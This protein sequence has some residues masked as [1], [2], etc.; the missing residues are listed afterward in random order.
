MKIG[1]SFLLSLLFITSVVTTEAQTTKKRITTKGKSLKKGVVK[2]KPAAP[3][4]VPV[5]EA[6]IPGI[7]VKMVTNFGEMVLRLSD[8][9][10]KHR[11]NF[12]KL[13]NEHF[14]DSLLFHRVIQAFMIQGGDPQSKHAM[15]GVPL[16]M[17]S[18]GYT[19][20]AEFDSTLFHKKGALC[21]A[22]TNNPEKASSGCQFY[23]VQGKPFGDNELSL[24]ESQ[25]QWAYTSAQKMT[26][27]MKGGT[28]HLD[29]NYTVFGELEKGFE[30]LDK[31]AIT[32]CD[33][34]NRPLEDVVI[35]RMEVVKETE[36]STN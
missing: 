26:Y 9:T 15:A 1:I 17:G 6:V 13:V 5:V 33:P 30:V 7:R 29:M 32:P 28:P 3:V 25:R 18:N 21:A 34:N 11:D 22:R 24:M 19:I 23:I 10:P 16:G 35:I 14:Y 31:I 36:P 8:K 2:K 27:K 12:V 4:G 20:P